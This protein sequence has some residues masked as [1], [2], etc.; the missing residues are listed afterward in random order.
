MPASKQIKA[1]VSGTHNILPN[2]VIPADAAS[3][4]RN[5]QTVFGAIQL[6]YGR[7]LVGAAGAAGKNYGEHTGFKADGTPVRFRKVNTKIQALIGSTW[8]DVITGLTEAADYTF[9]NYSSLAGAFVYIFGVDGIYKICTAN[10]TSYASL[11]DATKN[12]KGFGLIDKGRTILWGRAEDPTGLY[13]SHIDP[14]DGDV[15]TTVE[16]EVIADTASGTLEFKA[17]SSK[18]TC[19][20][21]AITDTTTGEVFT[22]DF[23]GN[24]VGSLGG[25]GTINYMT[26]AFTTEGSGAGTADYQWEDSNS[27]GLTDFTKSSPREAAEGFVLRQDAYGT[28]IKTVLALD[29]SYFSLKENCAYQLTIDAT[30]LAPVNIIFR[31]DIG[32]SSL[33]SA[34]ATG[35]GIIFINT[36]NPTEPILQRLTR[37]P[38][39]DN[40]DVKAMVPQFNF[41]NY[42]F[43]DA[44][45]DNWD[46]YIIIGC[47]KDADEND[48]L[49]LV[50]LP[51][52]VVDETAYGIRAAAKLNGAL[53]GGDPVSMS[54]YE[55]FSGFDDIGLSVMNSWES[56]GETYGSDVLKKVKRM[57]FKGQIDPA[58]AIE[59][60]VSYDD[61]DF[62]LVGT[63]LG[64]GG[65]VDAG[66]PA[67][68]G[69]TF[70]GQA[71]VGGNLVDVY[72]Y[73]A[74]LKVK[75]PKFRKRIIRLV[76]REIGFVSVNQITDFDIWTYQDKMPA[77]YRIKQN[78]ALAGAPVDMANPEF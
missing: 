65:Y 45:V 48:T 21:V 43:D 63:I 72:N 49:L 16:N 28:A 7:A 56:K 6:I 42:D 44:L 9:A 10:P 8:T 70:V 68:V 75:T 62:T 4:S 25:T 53:H 20:G 38:L 27:G 34:T 23:N 52:K 51:N 14:Q 33:R 39:G 46:R 15:Y 77:K 61:S 54:T 41:A 2:E 67:A 78:V 59:V 11:Y 58:Q 76:A 37:N 26:G 57:R 64:S 13:G 31:T 40:F 22:D 1:F 19:F 35:L 71:A 73:F 29:G 60:Y 47:K 24:L 3:K 32:V 66:A 30:D 5:W 55:L 69:T 12:F 50:D 36:A 17:G 18:R 74:E